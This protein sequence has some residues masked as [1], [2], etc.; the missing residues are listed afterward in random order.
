MAAIDDIRV[1]QINKIK[2]WDEKIFAAA[3]MYVE[4]G[5]YVLPIRRGGKLL[6]GKTHGISYPQAT[7][8]PNTIKKWFGPEGRFEGW[9]IGIAGGKEEGCFVVDIDDKGR[10]NGSEIF[11]EVAPADYKY[12]G[13][14]QRT[15]SGG[16]HLF[17]NWKPGC[18]NSTSKIGRE[19]IEARRAAEP[20]GTP[21]DAKSGIDTR[22]G[23]IKHPQGHVVAWPSVVGDGQ[24]EWINGGEVPDLP[25]FLYEYFI[26]DILV[27]GDAKGRGNEEVRDQ[28]KEEKF[29]LGQIRRILESVHPEKGHDEWYR[30][31]AAVHSQHPTDQGLALVDEWSARDKRVDEKGKKLYDPNLIR[32]KWKSYDGSKGIRIGT[33]LYYAKN[34]DPEFDP[35]HLKFIPP[36]P[37]KLD[38]VVEELNKS[39]AVIPLGSDVFILEEIKVPAELTRIQPS[40][41]ILKK[42]G[43]KSLLENRSEVSVDP[44]GRLVPKTHADIFLAHENRRTYP[45]GM[46]LFPNKPKRYMGYYNMWQGF[47]A[48]PSPGNWDLFKSHIK[49]IIC[50]GDEDL[51]DWVMDWMAD[52]YQDPANPKGCALVMHGIEG[53]GKGTFAQYLG[54]AFGTH[55]KHLLDEEHLIGRFNAHLADAIFVFADEITYGGNKKT[56]G[57]LKGMVTEKYLVSE[58]KGVDA[59]QFH[60]CTHLVV[61]SNEDWF[62]PAGPDSRRWLVLE[63]ASYR[64]ND[65]KYFQAINEQMTNGGLEA[66]MHELMNRKITNDLRKAPVTKALKYQRG[67]YASADPVLSWISSQMMMGGIKIRDIDDIEGQSSKPWPEIVQSSDAYLHCKE[68]CLE[69]KRRLPPDVTFGK[70]LN[71]LG[72]VKCRPKVNNK[73]IY[74]YRVPTR[75]EL[76]T[77]LEA[78]GVA[79]D[80]DEDDNESED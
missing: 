54:E 6:P 41:R 10:V 52:L 66:M 50:A 72:F 1:D 27:A 25:D 19:V 62:I 12:W 42:Q 2:D 34:D 59:V 70:A 79:L 68:W 63:V 53:C 56:A 9:N 32:A 28:D 60:N 8:N 69:N 46:G 39:F 48:T 29:S 58:R 24:Y 26:S 65:K 40:F 14:C 18:I 31:M 37:D 13:P 35:K 75:E 33:L 43:F 47:T 20:D 57:K 49:N 7:R 21:I 71:D 67:R 73:R 30:C 15:P 44:N 4:Y 64:A 11:K 36:N 23:T 17:F 77:K 5:F 78:K 61:S 3:T 55:F 22:G 45:S 76:L 51:F 74:G 16:F 38:E 80:I